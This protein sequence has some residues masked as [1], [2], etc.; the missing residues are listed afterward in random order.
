MFSVNIDKL[1]R[2]TDKEAASYDSIADV[3]VNKYDEICRSISIVGKP[4]CAF[5]IASAIADKG[6]N[7]LFIDADVSNSVFLSKYRLGKDL[8]GFAEYIADDCTVDELK[9]VTNK[10][11]LNIMFTGDTHRIGRVDKYGERIISLFMEAMENYDFVI[12][13]AEEDG[14]VSA[15]CAGTIIIMNDDDYTKEDAAKVAKRLEDNGCSVLGVIID[16][17]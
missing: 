15:Y 10:D 4:Q 13:A 2:M 12:A 6:K 7:V 17:Q 9:C 14:Y 5:K 8:K 11:E 3:I 16:E 1:I